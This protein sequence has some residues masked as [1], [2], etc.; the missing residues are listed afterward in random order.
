MTKI[1]IKINSV[2]LRGHRAATMV[3]K[4]HACLMGT[5]KNLTAQNSG[6]SIT[7]EG[8]NAALPGVYSDELLLVGG[9]HE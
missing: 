1:Y 9:H 4:Y 2:T 5:L 8:D 7:S 3:C 6:V